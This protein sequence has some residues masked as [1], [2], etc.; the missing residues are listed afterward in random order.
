MQKIILLAGFFCLTS[1]MYQ[2]RAQSI[3]NRVW[4]TYIGAPINDTAIFHVY[5]DSSFITNNN[6]DVMV[7]FHSK[8]SGDT[9][10]ILD[11]GTEEQGCPDVKGNYKVSYAENS[12]TLTLINDPC[13]GR[14]QALAGRKWIEATKK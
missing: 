10:T 11:F 12:L 13:E 9:L 2:L 6:G 7:R 8:I 3:N 14:S 1:T 5:P 4:K